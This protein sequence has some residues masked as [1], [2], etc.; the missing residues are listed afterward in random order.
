[1][2]CDRLERRAA[3]GVE[4]RREQDKPQITQIA[5]I[6]RGDRLIVLILSTD[7]TDAGDALCPDIR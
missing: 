3:P 4:G 1:M 5:Q 6:C 7:N 2:P